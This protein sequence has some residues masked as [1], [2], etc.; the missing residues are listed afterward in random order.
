MRLVF[1]TSPSTKHF[2]LLKKCNVEHILVSYHLV[3]K[4]SE[5]E[6]KMGDYMPK[7]F[8]L[9]SGA[10]SVWANG[11]HIDL[12]AYTQFA[13]R[14]REWL[15]P[16]VELNVVNLDVLPGKFGQTPTME[17]R[18]KSAEEGWKNMLALEA[19]GLKVIHVYHQHEDLKWL[20]QMREHLPYIGISPAND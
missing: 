15:P 5:L 9:D 13:K 2:E 10:F 19:E 3:K 1:A 8:I 6:R 18:E 14:L 17:E 11:G 12:F 16:E 20:H 4:V 7:T